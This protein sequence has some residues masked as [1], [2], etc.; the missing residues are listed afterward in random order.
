MTVVRRNLIEFDIWSKVTF[1]RIW[2]LIEFDKIW[3]NLTFDRR[4][5]INK[6]WSNTTFDRRDAI[7]YYIWSIEKFS[8]NWNLIDCD[9][10]SNT[11][12]DRRNLIEYDIWSKER[13][14]SDEELLPSGHRRSLKVHGH[15]PPTN[16]AV[17]AATKVPG[18][19]VKWNINL[20]LT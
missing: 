14:L 13:I 11:K 20:K 7:E 15:M 2:H 9:I 18:K 10:W 6:I 12:F 1:D 4:N 16:P 5:L 3:S 17:P 8:H 19:F